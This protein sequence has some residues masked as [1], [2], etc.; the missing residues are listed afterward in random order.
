[1]NDNNCFDENIMNCAALHGNVQ[2]MSIEWGST[3]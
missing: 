3:Y 1:M 2:V